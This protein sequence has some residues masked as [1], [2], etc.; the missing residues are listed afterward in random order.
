[1]KDI[2]EGIKKIK[3]G[4]AIQT[5]L[6]SSKDITNSDN[7]SVEGLI[8]IYNDINN[9]KPIKV[10]L[11]TAYRPGDNGIS[12]LA[13]EEL[14]NIAARITGETGIEAIYYQESKPR[15]VSGNLSEAEI[16]KEMINLLKRRPC[17][18]EDI[19][20]RFG[21]KK[22]PAILSSLEAKGLI[23][24]RKMNSKIFYILRGDKK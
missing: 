23:T 7:D 18:K 4:V 16:G 9:V 19:S 12:P 11:G 24:S 21:Y 8:S 5:L 3:T 6:F 15:R 17:T 10:F 2:A 22:A 14:K 13:K 1:M 20:S